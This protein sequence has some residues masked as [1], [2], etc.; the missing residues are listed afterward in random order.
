MEPLKK[1]WA[2][3]EVKNWLYAFGIFLAI[4]VIFLPGIF[5]SP[6]GLAGMW[7]LVF[8]GL[9]TAGFTAYILTPIVLRFLKPLK[10]EK[11]L[12]MMEQLSKEAGM[13]KAPRLTIAETAEINAVAYNSIFGKRIGITTGLLQAYNDEKLDDKELEGILAHELGHHKS[14]DT[15]KNSFVFSFVSLIEGMGYLIL[16]TGTGLARASEDLT[17]STA[18]LLA[19][20][21]GGIIALTG[22][23][24]RLVAKL[25]SAL[26]FHF[27]RVQ[28]Y[29]ADAFGAELRGRETM[30]NALRKIHG[31]NNELVAKE[32]SALPYA[33]RWQLRPAKLSWVDRLFS[34]H[35]STEKR[36]KAL[37][38][39]R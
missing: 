9:I 37:L 18:G 19:M 6:E 12:G 17:E 13:K 23:I 28:E 33:N 38:S 21:M 2:K 22:L 30:A 15:L 39:K 7:V 8:F 31:L 5:V 32:V 36:I 11:V 24:M 3:R 16:V 4:T 35:P 29:R 20:L 25:V 1:E 34:T 26:A 14:L 27:S 10:D